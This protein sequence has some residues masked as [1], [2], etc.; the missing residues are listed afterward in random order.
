MKLPEV[1]GLPAFLDSCTYT[2]SYKHELHEQHVN[3][4]S[5]DDA[6]KRIPPPDVQQHDDRRGDDLRQGVARAGKVHI[7]QAVHHEHAHDRARQELPEP[8]Y[9]GGRLPAA[10]EHEKRREADERRDERGD[11]N[12]Q[13]GVR[14]HHTLSP[15]FFVRRASS[16]KR[17]QSMPPIVGSRKLSAPNRRRQTIETPRPMSAGA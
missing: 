1:L 11:R 13:N 8:Q 14:I 6:Q 5:G 3:D 4:G 17:Q 12:E 2:G 15:P 9:H 16:T 10:A 7:P